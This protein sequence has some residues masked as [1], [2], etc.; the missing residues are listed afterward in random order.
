M[1]ATRDPLT[2][3]AN[4]AE[5][6]NRLAKIL[7]ESQAD[8]ATP[9]SAIFLDIDHF[10]SINDE[11]SHQVGDQVLVDVAH[12]IEFAPGRGDATPPRGPRSAR[13][14]LRVLW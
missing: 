13:P 7:E 14:T 9:F 6:E 2:G 3:L 1:A 10:K 4:R 8:G 11:N 12:L 5:M